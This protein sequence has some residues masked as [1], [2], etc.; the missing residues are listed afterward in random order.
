AVVIS[1]KNPKFLSWINALKNCPLMEE[2]LP[3]HDKLVA[4]F[5][6]FVASAQA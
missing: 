1:E 5:R 2:T 4:W 3:P 6:V